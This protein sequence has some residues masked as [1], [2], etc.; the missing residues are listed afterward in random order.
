MGA[1]EL[2]LDVVWSAIVSRS[3]RTSGI[4]VLNEGLGW[5]EFENSSSGSMTAA[6]EPCLPFSLSKSVVIVCQFLMRNVTGLFPD[7]LK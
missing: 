2:K 5:D 7:A 4:G 1:A 6:G 3:S